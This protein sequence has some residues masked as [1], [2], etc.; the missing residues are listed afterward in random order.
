[1]TGG[2]RFTFQQPLDGYRFS[3]DAT[4]LVRFALSVSP[5]SPAYVVDLGAGCGVVGLLLG[6]AWRQCK[7]RLVEIQSEL[8]RHA[9]LNA[10]QLG[11]SDRVELVEGDFRHHQLW[12]SNLRERLLLVCNPPFH[13]LGTARLPPS[14]AQAVARHELCASLRETVAALCAP[15][16][17]SLEAIVVH[18]ASRGEELLASLDRAGLRQRY[19]QEFTLKGGQSRRI[20]IHAERSGSLPARRAKPL[21]CG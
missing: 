3:A 9:Q 12:T 8:S 7:V 6:H 15:D 5:V 20:L 17:V 11:L 21:R 2:R 1:M 10:R 19:V 14:R 13:R 4:A 16:L 18:L